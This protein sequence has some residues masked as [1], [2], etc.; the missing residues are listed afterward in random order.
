MKEE[1]RGEEVDVNIVQ[2]EWKHMVLMM[3][4]KVGGHVDACVWCM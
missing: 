1:T 3:Q 2:R 4:G